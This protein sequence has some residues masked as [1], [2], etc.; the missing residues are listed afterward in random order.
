MYK[1]WSATFTNFSN[2]D[3]NLTDMIFLEN[4][5]RIYTKFIFSQKFMRFFAYDCSSFPSL[6]KIKPKENVQN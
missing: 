1:L 6:V 5:S 3:D 4:A 2:M